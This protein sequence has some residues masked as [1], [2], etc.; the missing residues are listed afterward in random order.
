M[1][2]KLGKFQMINFQG[3]APKVTKLNHISAMFGQSPQKA[4]DIMVQL[5]AKNVRT[6]GLYTLLS[7]IPSKQFDTDDEYTWE[8]I[9]NT[10]RNIPLVGARDEDGQP[11]FG[12]ENKM[13]GAGVAPFELV[14]PEAWFFDG[15]V[16]VGDFDIYP[17]RILGDGRKEGVNTVYTVELM[18]G[19]TTGMPADLLAPGKRFSFEYAPVERE[20]SRKVGGR[21]YILCHLVA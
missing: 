8:V 5:Y 9:G 10:R 14:F 11:I 15:E 13:I 20:L 7:Q 4:T 19:N 6:N 21:L 16:L 2:G 18:A 3:Y 1:A 17:L 12:T